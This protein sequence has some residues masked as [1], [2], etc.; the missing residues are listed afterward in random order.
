M[1][2]LMSYGEEESFSFVIS[3]ISI[4]PIDISES[5]KYPLMILGLNDSDSWT[6]V[7][8]FRVEGGSIHPISC[9]SKQEFYGFDFPYQI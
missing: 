6:L 1:L 4:T 7:V 5:T 2:S 8:A 3:N 9:G